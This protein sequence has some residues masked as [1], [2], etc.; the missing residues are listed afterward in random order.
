MRRNLEAFCCDL[1]G[2]LC[3]YVPD[4]GN[5][6]PVSQRSYDNDSSSSLYLMESTCKSWHSHHNGVK[7]SSGGDP[8]CPHVG[9]CPK[10]L[11]P[12]SEGDV[13]FPPATSA[14]VPILCTMLSSLSTTS[15]MTG[16]VLHVFPGDGRTAQTPALIWGVKKVHARNG[17]VNQVA[18]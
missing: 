18:T 1:V 6:R 11:G 7:I 15:E 4:L 12:F 8:V 9:C 13:Y 17:D 16:G 5:P 2:R 3:H 10:A 14:K